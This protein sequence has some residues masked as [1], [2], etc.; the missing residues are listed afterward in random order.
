MADMAKLRPADLY[1]LAYRYKF[2][3][4]FY[5]YFQYTGGPRNSRTFYLLIRGPRMCT[6][7][8]DTWSF[9]RLFTDF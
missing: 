6:K 3:Q 9:P 1:S 8:K 5:L 7:P 2:M 4:Y